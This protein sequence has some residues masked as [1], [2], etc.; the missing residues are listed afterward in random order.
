MILSPFPSRVVVVVVVD[1]GGL[2]VL[3]FCLNQ[4][5]FEQESGVLTYVEGGKDFGFF[6]PFLEKLSLSKENFTH[7]NL[8]HLSWCISFFKNQDFEIEIVVFE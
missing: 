1:G 2:E 5:G 7:P 3:L 4:R 6:S 8:L